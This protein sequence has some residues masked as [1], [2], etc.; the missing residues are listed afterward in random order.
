MSISVQNI[1][2]PILALS[3]FSLDILLSVDHLAMGSLYIFVMIL[4][5]K[6]I[7]T[8][9]GYQASLLL[10]GSLMVLSYLLSSIT[11]LTSTVN[12]IMS[13]VIL[14]LTYCVATCKLETQQNIEQHNKELEDQKKTLEQ[15]KKDLEYFA[16]VASHDLKEPLRRI[17]NYCHLLED[18][19]CHC[20][21]NDTKY[22][23]S[24]ISD[25]TNRLY[26]LISDLLKFSQVGNKTLCIKCYT[27]VDVLKTV[28]ED[29]RKRIDE[30]EAVINID[31]DPS[32][33]VQADLN[34][35]YCSLQNLMSNG[36]KFVKEEQ[37]PILDIYITDNDKLWNIHFKDNGI[38]IQE[39]YLN[40]IFDAFQ[41]LH[42][43]KEYSGTGIGLAI[44]MKSVTA[45]NG[46]LTVSSV[47]HKGSIFTISLPKGIQ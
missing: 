9:R 1:L 46:T 2:I 23:I 24:A 26:L 30:V 20:L 16:Y 43:K 27:V 13:L 25:S 22:F 45:M 38:G 33:T 28:I 12:R 5:V 29:L 6:V 3:V 42:N 10:I 36:L 40:K 4:L 35:L 21:D 47:E 17:N 18:E 32:V 39:K 8:K 44:T 19:L 11:D 7:Q 41:R 31:V 15:Q 34:L 37:K 14:G